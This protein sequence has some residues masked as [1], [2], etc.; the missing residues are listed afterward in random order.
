MKLSVATAL[1]ICETVAAVKPVVHL[2]YSSFQGTPLDNGITQWLG[3]PFAAP[4]VGDLR[5]RAPRDPAKTEGIQLANK[6]SPSCIGTG[7]SPSATKSEDC[8]YA[9]V[10]APTAATRCKPLPVYVWIMGGGFNSNAGPNS[11]GTGLIR[12][13]DMDLVVVTFN[14]RVGTYG[15]MTNGDAS[16]TTLIDTNMG[17][18]DQRKLL[19]WVQSHIS[20][21][22][23]DPRHVV[24]GGASAGAASVTYH[25][26]AYDGA[27]EGLFV[28]AAAESQ[29]FGPVRTAEKSRYQFVNLAKRLGCWDESAVSN[30]DEDKSNDAAVLACMR[31]A[32]VETVQQAASTNI[33]YPEL[34]SAN[35]SF[36]QAPLYMF[37]PLID[38]KII[39]DLT[40][41]RFAEGKY[42]H[43]P[44]I[45]GDDTNEG[46]TFAPKTAA[47]RQDSHDFYRAN[48]PAATAAQL[49]VLDGLYPNHNESTCPNKG[50]WWR[51]ASDV[52]GDTRYTCPGLF[53]AETLTDPATPAGPGEKQP[54]KEKP[55]VFL[56]R[57]NALDPA[58][59]ASGL[60]VPHTVETNAVWGP[61]N[62][63]SAAPKSYLPGGVNA[64]VVPVVQGY[65]TSFIR[66][67]DPNSHRVPGSAEWENWEGKMD[68]PAAG[69]RLLFSTGGGTTMEG[70]DDG[71]ENQTAKCRY[72]ETIALDLQQ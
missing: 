6:H 71:V 67:L 52:Y 12:A 43:V 21:F 3:M 59:E 50:C 61:E 27:D 68:G 45:F 2:G 19:R 65:W 44:S 55:P 30:N 36:S 49:S 11:N 47:T 18:L 31:S 14:Y 7:E 26:T 53:L 38:G 4:P 28:G 20:K 40:Y 24:I 29:S 10:Y 60:G 51:Q 64:G 15:F 57:Y 1:A 63:Q 35:S 39:Q 16:D 5:W 66:T 62:L 34:T 58:Q 23:G 8:L 25:L 72:L 46:T 9:A 48:F 17:L 22:G 70:V 69:K 54:G 13:A 33:P 56:Y 42:I 32:P 37:S 41:N